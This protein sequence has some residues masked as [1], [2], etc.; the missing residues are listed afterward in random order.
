LIKYPVI[1]ERANGNY[2][3]YCPDLPGCVATGSNIEET[4]KQIKEAIQFHLEGMKKE[5]L[6]ILKPSTQI[7]YIE[8]SV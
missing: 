8:V 5:G 3:A 1:I 2:S 7:K 6:K 4:I